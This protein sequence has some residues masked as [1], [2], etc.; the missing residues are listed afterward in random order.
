MWSNHYRRREVLGSGKTA[1]ETLEAAKAIRVIGKTRGGS[2]LLTVDKDPGALGE[3]KKAIDGEGTMKAKR[4]G[5][6]GATESFHLKGVADDVTKD[7]VS[8]AIKLSIGQ[9][10]TSCEV[11]ER[12]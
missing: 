5:G 9:W 7:E 1:V 8:E 11:S 10:N 12:H 6:D 4:L 2:L 3:I